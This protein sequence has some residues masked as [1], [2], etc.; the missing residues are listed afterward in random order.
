MA[1]AGSCDSIERHGP[2]STSGLLDLFEVTGQRREAIESAR[3]SHSVEI[4]HPTH[5]SAWIRDNK[6][7]NETVLRRTL[8][9]MSGAERYRELNGR[10]FFLLTRSRLDRL[11][12]EPHTVSASTTS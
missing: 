4:T 10:L 6:P 2:L 3:S 8:A 12:G 9:G 1:E 5:R 11:R 7:I